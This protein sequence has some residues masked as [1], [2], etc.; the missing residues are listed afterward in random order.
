MSLLC[1]L[2][3]NPGAAWALGSNSWL[4]RVFSQQVL[5]ISDITVTSGVCCCL[6]TANNLE[7]P[8]NFVTYKK[9]SRQVFLWHCSDEVGLSLASQLSVLAKVPCEEPF[10]LSL[11]TCTSWIDPTKLEKEVVI[12][13]NLATAKRNAYSS[14]FPRVYFMFV[15][16]G[17]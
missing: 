5:R 14:L 3:Q 13:L 2:L 4:L 16:W 1:G 7:V 11:E 9:T 10:V 8:C 15:Q 6:I 12:I 17:I